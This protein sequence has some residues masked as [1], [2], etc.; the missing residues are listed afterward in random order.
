MRRNYVLVNRKFNELESMIRLLFGVR[1]FKCAS[2][3]GR[4]AEASPLATEQSPT[5]DAESDDTKCA[6]LHTNSTSL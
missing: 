4:R 6:Y 2:L 3:S 5:R 1:D